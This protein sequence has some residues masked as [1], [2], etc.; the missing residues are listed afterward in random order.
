MRSLFLLRGA[1]GAGKSTWIKQNGLEPYTLSAD[2]IRCMKA[3]LVYTLSGKRQIPNNYENTVWKMLME[4]LEDR[5]DRGEMVVVDATH[6]RAALLTAYKKLITKYRYRAYVVDF[7][8]VPLETALKQNSMRA[9]YKIVPPEVIQKMYEVFRSDYKEVSTRFKVIS[10]EEALHIMHSSLLFDYDEYEKVVIFGDIHGCYTPLEKYFADHPMRND[11]AYIFLG[12]YL[13]RGIQNKEV[14]EFLLKVKD[15]P[16]VLLLEGNHER[17]LRMYAEGDYLKPLTAEEKAMLRPYVDKSFYT[18]RRRKEIRNSG[19]LRDTLPQIESIPKKDL[20]NLCR[21]MGQMA[22]FTFG[23]NDYFV[24]HGGTPML[25]SL[26]VP[27]E[28]YID[29]VGKYEDVDA[30]YEAWLRNTDETKIMVH[31]HRNIFHYPAQMNERCYNLCSDIEYGGA[32]RIMEISDYGINILQYDNPVYDEKLKAQR[33]KERVDETNMKTVPEDLLEQMEATNLIIKK[34]FPNGIASYNFTRKAFEEGYWNHL[35]CTARGLFVKDGKVVARSYNKFFNW[36]E[37]ETTT[38][39]SLQDKMRFPV[40]AYKK[41]N[42][43]LALVSHFEDKLLVCS[44]SSITGPYVDYIKIHLGALGKATQDKMLAYAKE[45]DCTFVFECVDPLRDPHIVRYNSPHFVLL[46][47]VK[48]DL[49]YEALPYEDMIAV[50][51]EIGLEHKEKT[52]VFYNWKELYQF[53]KWLDVADV[54]KPFIEGYVLEDRNGLKVKLKTATYR[55]WK[56]KRSILDSMKAGHTVKPVYNG[57]YDIRLFALMNRLKESGE[58]DRMNILDLQ[59]RFAKE[60]IY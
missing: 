56:G 4:L 26:F 58:L 46:D 5:M 28:Q 14:L 9:S 25:P 13:D 39:R 35:T 16:N 18:E 43:F 38:S 40:T 7:T 52:C 19:F 10:R 37:R 21:R 34:E 29:G 59:D 22:Y 33:A 45:H 6:Y 55:W 44:K 36:G 20:R 2:D 51:K 23:G 57:A 41:E 31:G 54:G 60:C 27:A 42:G 53:K 3:G 24:T 49:K 47:I 15:E 30:L 8:D 11:T 1:P 32:L 50:A 48:N 12:D 17:W